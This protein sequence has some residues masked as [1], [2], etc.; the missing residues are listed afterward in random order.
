MKITVPEKEVEVCDICQREGCLQ[1]CI[2]C[3]GRYCL[4]CNGI[5][6]GCIH[7]VDVCR[8]CGKNGIVQAIVEKHVPA[9]TAVL[10]TRDTEIIEAGQVWQ[11]ERAEEA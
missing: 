6:P 10:N 7:K 11:A 3:D 9:I 2:H 4:T 1:T 8:K 5:M